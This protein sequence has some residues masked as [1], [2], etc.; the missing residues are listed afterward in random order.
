M[1]LI[2]ASHK[3]IRGPYLV[4]GVI[5]GIIAAI[6]SFLIWIPII[7]GGNPYLSNFIPELDLVAYLGS[8]YVALLSYQLLFGISL[9]VVS[10]FIA[11]RRY[12]K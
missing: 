6:L 9:S 2:G 12:F 8:H 11:I 5:Y 3:F 4:E 7:K 10:S 1:Q